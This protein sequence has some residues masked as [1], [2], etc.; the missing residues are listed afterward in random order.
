MLLLRSSPPACLYPYISSRRED[1]T[2]PTGHP[3]GARTLLVPN[4][5]CHLSAHHLSFD[6]SIA[7][8]PSVP[9]YII[10]N[11]ESGPEGSP[12]SQP[13]TPFQQCVPQLLEFANVITL[14][15]VIT[16]FGAADRQ[17]GVLADVNTYAGWA[18]SYRPAGI[19]FDEV[20]NLAADFETYENFTAEARSLFSFVSNLLIFRVVEPSL[21]HAID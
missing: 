16:G 4:T 20:S 10:I 2:A 3:S 21:M 13:P 9:F 7:A 17:A 19:F 12:G 15:Y 5:S 1:R 8:H 14:G 11:P 6:F 18:S